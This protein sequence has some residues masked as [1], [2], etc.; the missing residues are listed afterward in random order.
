LNCRPKQRR[1]TGEVAADLSGS[2][3][4]ENLAVMPTT[5]EMNA[6]EWLEPALDQMWFEWLDDEDDERAG[7]LGFV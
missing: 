3:Q 4:K 6:P 2:K 1:L 5:L 7:T